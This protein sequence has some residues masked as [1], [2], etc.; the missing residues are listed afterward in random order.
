MAKEE[1]VD[2]SKFRD[3]TSEKIV[4]ALRTDEQ[5]RDVN[6]V[7]SMS[8]NI[9]LFVRYFATRYFETGVAN[10]RDPRGGRRMEALR[11]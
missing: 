4:P 9:A 2:S 3:D 10:D 6:R 5:M 11:T 8:I 7:A 1:I